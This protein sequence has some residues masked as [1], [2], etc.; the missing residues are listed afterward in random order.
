M[1]NHMSKLL[2]G[3]V[4]LMT[5]AFFTCILHAQ[6]ITGTIR[7]VVYDPS[8]AGVPAASVTATQMETGLSR[9][10]VTDR[11]GTY[12]LV[13][14]PVGHYRL[15]VSAKGFQNLTQEGITLSVNQSANVPVHLEIGSPTEMVQVTENAALIETADTTL[16]ETVGE[17]E[18]LDLPLNGPDSARRKKWRQWVISLVA[19]PMISIICLVL[20]SDMPSLP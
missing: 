6:E 3:L 16:G 5:F 9:S 2:R 18:I 20:S 17:R 8:G 14:L 13:L 10:A 1:N 12:V 15:K 7:G 11:E 4:V 19:S